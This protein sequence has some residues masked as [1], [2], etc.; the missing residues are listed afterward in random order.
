MYV[1]IH[2]Q[3][4]INRNL[5][6]QH[7]MNIQQLEYILAVDKF[8]HFAKAAENCRVTQPTLSAMIQKLED[9]LGLKLFDRNMQPVEATQAGRK[10][11]EQARKVLFEISLIKDIAEEE[12][13]S[14][15]GSFHLAVLPTIAP[16]LLPRFFH[17]LTEKNVELDIRV[18]EMKSAQALMALQRGEID[19]A[20][21]ANKPVELQ[22]KA[23]TLYYEQFFG[24]VSRNEP[25][26]KKNLIRTS[27]ID[28]ERLWLLDEGHCFRD[29]F[30]RFCQMDKVKIRQATYRLGSMET[31]MRMVESGNGVTFI[32]ELATLQLSD[33]QKKL[34]RPFAI[35]RPTR[36]ITFITRKDFI[37]NTIADIIK[38]G[39]KD[40][41]PNEMLTLSPGLK[42]V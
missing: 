6:F 3:L 16:Y 29:Q 1:C 32:P 42:I 18:L 34:V 30:M 2:I 23:E 4:I 25:I 5:I 11:I 26:F 28:G 7:T 36:E 41:I 13:M 14:V 31:F 12:K 27:D 19:A 10:I 9:E 21:L 40:S 38:K 22:L 37:R 8:H 20:I 24:Y 17:Q 15:K 39:I 33:E 35:P